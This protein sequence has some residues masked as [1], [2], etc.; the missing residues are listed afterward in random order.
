MHLFRPRPF[1]ERDPPSPPQTP[2]SSRELARIAAADYESSISNL[3]SIDKLKAS[4]SSFIEGFLEGYSQV[5]PGL[6]DVPHVATSSGSS[7]SGSA[8]AE[9]APV[10]SRIQ[11][12]ARER[13]FEMG[14]APA[15]GAR[16]GRG[17]PG[18]GVHGS[19]MLPTAIDLE[20]GD[21]RTPA[22]ARASPAAAR[23]PAAAHHVPS[24]CGAGHD[25]HHHSVSPASR[26]KREEARDAAILSKK[27]AK[28][29]EAQKRCGVTTTW[30]H[31]L[32]TRA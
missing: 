11:S 7:S 17:V 32:A 28:E 1:A 16:A 2:I 27:Q 8:P 26:A 21:S 14:G 29:A 13:T 12:K 9:A 30:A 31:V 3:P 18:A 4:K 6:A 20:A 22:A 19:S 24:T 23:A 5:V 10:A 25:F 15:D